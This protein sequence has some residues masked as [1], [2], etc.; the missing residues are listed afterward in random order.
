MRPI[1]GQEDQAG[2]AGPTRSRIRTHSDSTKKHRFLLTPNVQSSA[3][4]VTQ[5]PRHKRPQ[6]PSWQTNIPQMNLTVRPDLCLQQSTFH[7]VVVQNPQNWRPFCIRCRGLRRRDCFGYCTGLFAPQGTVARLATRAGTEVNWI[8]VV[9]P[10]PES[11]VVENRARVR[12]TNSRQYIRPWRGGT[13][14][15]NNCIPQHFTSRRVPRRG[16]DG[17]AHLRVS[18]S[19]I[20]AKPGRPS[21]VHT[22]CDPRRHS[23]QLTLRIVTPT[24]E[25]TVVEDSA[26]VI[27]SDRYARHRTARRPP[28]NSTATPGRRLCAPRTREREDPASSHP[29]TAGKVAPRRARRMT[30]RRRTAR[31]KS[32]R[33]GARGSRWRR[34]HLPTRRIQFSNC[35]FLYVYSQTVS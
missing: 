6:L 21:E 34:S 8:A 28:P 18:S 5:Y 32:A 9:S 17:A 3:V 13:R 20:V 16:S 23:A 22:P 29:T 4:T 2:R 27:I 15:S 26:R 12:N 31:V 10:Y 25:L 11:V 1:P 24:H 30:S 19:R 7:R 14:V 33:L 35:L